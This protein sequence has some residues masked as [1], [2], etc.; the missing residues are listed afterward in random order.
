MRRSYAAMTLVLPSDV[1][2]TPGARAMKSLPLISPLLMSVM[3]LSRRSAV[4]TPP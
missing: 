1:S 3:P 4:G 2:A